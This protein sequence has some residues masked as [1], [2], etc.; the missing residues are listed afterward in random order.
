MGYYDV[1]DLSTKA[2]IQMVPMKLI[3]EEA[4]LQAPLYLLSCARYLHLIALEIP[5]FKDVEI[6][7]NDAAQH[8]NEL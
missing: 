8:N 6:W 2:Q 5:P 7:L 1:P 3:K 4:V